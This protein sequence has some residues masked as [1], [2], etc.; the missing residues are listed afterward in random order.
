MGR[1]VGRV[2]EGLAGRVVNGPDGRESPPWH[3]FQGFCWAVSFLGCWA[4]R[5]RLYGLYEGGLPHYHRGRA[6]L[7]STQSGISRGGGTRHERHSGCWAVASVVSW[8]VG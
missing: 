3:G 8:A 2:V 4:A 1:V 6:F 7:H 5:V